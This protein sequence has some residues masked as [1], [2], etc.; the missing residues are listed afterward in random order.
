MMLEMEPL[1]ARFDA[2]VTAGMGEA[3]LLEA[4][5][6]ISFWQKP[7]PLTAW[8]VTGQPA[9][10]VPAGLSSRGL[11][12]AVQLLGR[13]SDEATLISLAAQIEAERRWPDQRPPGF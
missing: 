13:P 11:P 3:P 7:S 9:A 1:Y 10:S 5:R 8:N 4:Y 12:L 6:S 2:F